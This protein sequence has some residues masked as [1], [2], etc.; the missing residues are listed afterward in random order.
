[1]EAEYTGE[2]QP[3]TQ[4]VSRTVRAAEDCSAIIRRIKDF[5][6]LNV[7][8]RPSLI[9]INEPVASAVDLKREA[10]LTDGTSVDFQVSLSPVV[11]IYGDEVA[12]R[13]VLVNLIENS[14]ERPQR[15]Y[16]LLP[17]LPSTGD[18]GGLSDVPM[19]DSLPPRTMSST[20]FGAG[21][22]RIR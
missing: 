1:M 6:R 10:K 21:M 13:T 4:R 3:V 19:E 14:L 12:L 8:F 16:V 7:N 9:D 20:D 18:S 2:L 17:R 11:P 22:V 5:V 15:Q